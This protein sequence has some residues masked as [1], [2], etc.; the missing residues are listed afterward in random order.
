ML[1]ENMDDEK[2][3]D[4]RNEVPESEQLGDS[5][6]ISDSHWEDLVNQIAEPS[7]MMGDMPA[8]EVRERLEE[9]E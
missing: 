9:D 4:W 2:N 8:D 5:S 3:E 6:R 1:I 7:A